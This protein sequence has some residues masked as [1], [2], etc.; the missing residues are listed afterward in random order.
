VILAYTSYW[1]VGIFVYWIEGI[2]PIINISNY[3]IFL[4]LTV[5][6]GWIICRYFAQGL[7]GI[8]SFLLVSS[9]LSWVVYWNREERRMAVRYIKRR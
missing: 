4:L 6:S 9:I 2:N 1:I 8:I 7:T 5:F 3:L